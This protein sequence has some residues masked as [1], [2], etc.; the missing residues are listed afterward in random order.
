MPGIAR[1]KPALWLAVLLVAS[2]ATATADPLNFKGKDYLAMNENY[3]TGLVH[4][5]LAS[6]VD[7][8][9]PDRYKEFILYGYGCLERQ[10]RTI[11]VMAIEFG[12][13]IE[14]HY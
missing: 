3:R 5:L 10:R 2:A 12:R 14:S 9:S 6:W 11:P 8:G 7:L 13:Y 4:G 1:I